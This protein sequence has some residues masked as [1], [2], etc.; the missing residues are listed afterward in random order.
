MVNGQWVRD[1]FPNN[2]IPQ[3]RI[4]PV[5]QKF[6]QYFLRPNTTP[7]AGIDPWRNNFVFAPN[8]AR[9]NYHNVATKVDQNIS[10]KTRM[11]FRYAYNYRSENRYVN[12]IT[13]GPAQDGQLPLERVN[14]GGVVDWVRTVRSSLSSVFSRARATARS[15]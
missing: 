12:G 4:D 2:V 11:F 9:D 14:H 3:G 13:S 10:D 8:L 1:P 7:A 15:S 6:L 5:A